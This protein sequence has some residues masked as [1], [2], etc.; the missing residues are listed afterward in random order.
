M[1]KS[2]LLEAQANVATQESAEQQVTRVLLDRQVRKETQGLPGRLG[3]RAPLG[4]LGRLVDQ[5]LV[6]MRVSWV[7]WDPKDIVATAEKRVKEA[8]EGPRDYLDLQE[9]R[10]LWGV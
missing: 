2:A 5:G 3:K 1:D 10:G 7:T 6:E 8:N 9:Q 4:R